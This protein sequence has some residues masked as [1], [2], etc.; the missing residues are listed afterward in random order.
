MAKKRLCVEFIGF[1]DG[2]FLA[3]LYEHVI[4]EE[5]LKRNLQERISLNGKYIEPLVELD[6]EI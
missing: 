2:K 6:E 3:S 5:C 1:Q 4:E